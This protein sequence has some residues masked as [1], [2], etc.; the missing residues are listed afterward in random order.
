MFS[1]A[2]EAA[3][4]NDSSTFALPAA[5]CSTQ[6]LLQAFSQMSRLLHQRI[7]QRLGEARESASPTNPAH[8]AQTVRGPAQ[9]RSRRFAPA[10]RARATSLR[11]GAPAAVRR[12]HARRSKCRSR[13]PCRTAHAG[14]NNSPAPARTGKV[15]CSARTESARR[16][17]SRR[18]FARGDVTAFP[19]APFADAL[20]GAAA[21]G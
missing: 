14:A 4:S 13:Q 11:T 10:N 6:P 21:C 20:C 7:A 3:P 16:G 19:R 12:Q 15:P 5:M 17:E 18:R 1:P 8:R 9:A 2:A